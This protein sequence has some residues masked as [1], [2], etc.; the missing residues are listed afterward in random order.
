MLSPL[1]RGEG[2]T[3]NRG[4]GRD[5]APDGARD[6]VFLVE[7]ERFQGPMDLLLHLIRQQ[8]LDIFDI[9]IARITDQFLV[10]V[11][12]IQ[13][14]DLDSAGEFL[15]M[16]ATLIRI[17][18][19]LLLPRPESDE[20]EDPR[21]ELVRR[22]LEY[23]QVRE[24]THHMENA[25]AERSRRFSK[26]FVAPRPRTPVE[27]TALETTWDE[28]FQAAL[29]VTLPD[30]ASRDHR[31]TPR[32]VSMDE[33][34]L[35]ILSRL[36]EGGLGPGEGE[37]RVEFRALVAPFQERMH[38][39]MTFLAGLELSRRRRIHLRQ[40]APFH[41]LWLYWREREPGDETDPATDTLGAREE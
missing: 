24:I 33:K 30:L 17:K 26:G 16:A 32:T 22:L 4:A 10:A 29:E 41:D 12:G 14:S 3:G 13:A 19:Q 1:A 5:D 9:P 15:E 34:V 40:S 18:A 36:R 39:V 6:G 23:E 8:D 25:E 27:E 38:G 28:V 2:R 35:L 11:K 20:D 37:R 7:I 21:A 31:V